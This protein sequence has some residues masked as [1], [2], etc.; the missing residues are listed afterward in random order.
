VARAAGW[1]TAAL[2]G[3]DPGD[4]FVGATMLG[5]AE[6]LVFTAA[7]FAAHAVL[8]TAAVAGARVIGPARRGAPAA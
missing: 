6:L 5:R 2:V 8:A 7:F 1:L 4:R 3:G